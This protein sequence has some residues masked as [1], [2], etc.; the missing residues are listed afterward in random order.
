M[1]PD[2]Y[3]DNHPLRDAFVAN[4]LGRLADLIV[5]QGEE[6]LQDADLNFPSRAVSSVLLI[7]ER[8]K[9]SAADIAEA[10]NLPHQLVTQRI[11]LLIDLKIVKR[12]GDPKD[13]RRKILALTAR[14]AQQFERLKTLLASADRAF[15][16]LFNE[17][18]CDLHAVAAR[19]MD[20]LTKH[21]VL[22]RVRAA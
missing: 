12:V 19:A 20:A 17:I 10:L 22:D 9:I 6:L 8:G 2:T 1:M 4:L 11:D 13:G 15:K 14:G 18:E 16:V 7:G 21:P 5:A 3:T